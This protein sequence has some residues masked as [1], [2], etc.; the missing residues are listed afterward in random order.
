MT[1]QQKG[2]AAEYESHQ[3]D[4]SRPTDTKTG[5]V[6]LIRIRPTHLL[7]TDLVALYIVV[8]HKATRVAL[9]IP[10]NLPIWNIIMTFIMQKHV[11]RLANRYP[12]LMLVWWAFFAI[13][14]YYITN[15]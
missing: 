2:L 1:R 14:T 10:T 9:S 3:P 8:S 12:P 15:L 13:S 5:R 4:R 7:R 6:N 11:G